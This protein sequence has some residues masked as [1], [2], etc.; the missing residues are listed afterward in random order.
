MLYEHRIYKTGPGKC[1]NA[2][3]QE[4]PLHAQSRQRLIGVCGMLLLLYHEHSMLQ[5]LFRIT[6]PQTSDPH[7]VCNILFGVEGATLCGIFS[8][9]VSKVA[10]IESNITARMTNTR[11]VL[12]AII[13]IMPESR[14]L[15]S[16][17]TII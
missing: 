15:S 6:L 8:L 9:R 7:D 11:M 3:S 2:L 13:A 4:I 1:S 5:F 14:V 12:A 16:A 10:K 17:L